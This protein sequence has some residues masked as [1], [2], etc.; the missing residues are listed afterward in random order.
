MGR[1]QGVEVGVCEWGGG[2]EVGV[3]EWGGVEGE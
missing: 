1:E 3:W 2:G